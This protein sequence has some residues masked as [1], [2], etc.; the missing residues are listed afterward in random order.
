MSLR[1]RISGPFQLF[2]V[3]GIED[4]GSDFAGG[5]EYRRRV[6]IGWL[7]F[8]CGRFVRGYPVGCEPWGKP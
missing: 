5:R 8:D 6:R 3:W 2:A 1:L 7:T 4:G